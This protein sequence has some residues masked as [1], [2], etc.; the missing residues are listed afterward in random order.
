MQIYYCLQTEFKK[1]KTQTIVTFCKATQIMRFTHL[2][3]QLTFSKQQR[4][5]KVGILYNL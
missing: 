5:G 2:N 1:D 3:N 4:V